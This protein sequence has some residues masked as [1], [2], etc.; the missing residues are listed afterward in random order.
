MSRKNRPY[1][2]YD[3]TSSVCS[4]CLYPVEA[5]IIFKNNHV[6]MDK[7]CPVHGN[8]RVLM[9]DDVD[10]YRSCRE[11]YVKRPEMPE[12]FST[13]MQYGCPYDCGL[14]PDHMQHSCLTIVEITDV[15]NLDCP[16]CFADSG[17]SREVNLPH[18][19]YKYKSLATVK[20][21]LD[22]VVACEGEPDVV[23]LSG[24]EPTL[25]PELFAILDY[26][27]TL[28]IRHVMINTN[29]IRLAKEPEFVTRLADYAYR[30]KNQNSAKVQGLE[31][32]LQFDSLDDAHI[33]VLRGANLA[34]IHQQALANLETHNLS[35]TL[36][37]TIKKRL[38]DGEMGR[39]IEHGLSYR[40]VR[41]VSFQ[42]LSESGRIGLDDALL[43]ASKQRLTISQ[44]RRQIA[45][46]STVFTL[47][48]I[49][50]VPCNPDT[51]A[52]GYALKTYNNHDANH[53]STPTIPAPVEVTPL[54]RYLTPDVI[55][56]GGGNTILFEQNPDVQAQAKNQLIKVLST[57]HSPE[58]QADCLSELLCCLPKINAPHL[59]YDNVFRVMIVQFMDA[60]NLDIRALKKS[61]IHFAQPDGKMIPFESFNIFY[62][63]DKV[64]K[65][66][67]IRKTLETQF[68]ARRAVSDTMEDA[69]I[70][71]DI[72]A[73]TTKEADNKLNN[74]DKD[75]SITVYSV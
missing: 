58:S 46:Q 5:K 67:D 56:N 41:G 29:G 10:Y 18:L 69:I 28:P 27:Q 19:S 63:D 2:F 40:C 42:P 4:T 75:K 55:M 6:Y 38:N 72:L 33:H 52:M 3:T 62:R 60:Q 25:H 43:D 73:N 49:V 35:T 36:V 53:T 68:M 26:I 1:E 21:M 16:V 48:D 74:K 20:A 37:A 24:G 61:C 8:E 59:S 11:V 64:E 12:T 54:T 7:W 71:T 39:I 9:M 50:P 15:C 44:M 65:L 66:A 17:M 13:P 22:T 23:Q 30:L 51:L 31:I 45:E 34:R 57:N 70:G 14:C 47:D 32:Y